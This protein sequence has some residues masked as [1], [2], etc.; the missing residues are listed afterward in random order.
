MS[1]KLTGYVWDGCAASGMKLSSVAIMARLADFSNDEG[2]CWPSIET[3]A[4]QIGA[5][6][7]T[8][9]TAIARLEAE[10]WLTRKARRQGNRNAS[11]VYQLN[12]AKL[13]AA[14]FSQL[15]DS[16][17]SKFDAS[18]S[19]KKAGFHPS[20]SGG[21]PSVKSK[22][23]PSDKKTSRPDASQ[24]DTQTAEQE[25]L[26]RH[27][28]AV[29][30][31]PKKRQWG[32]QDD[33]TCAQWLWKKIIALYEQAAECDGEV[34]RPKEPNWT[35]WANEIRLMCVQDGRTHK[36]ICEMYS[37]VSRDPFW[38]RNVLSPSKL[39][40]KWDELSLRL[41]PSVSTYT[42]KREDPYFKASYD[43][44]DYSQIPAGFRG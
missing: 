23:D 25:F 24:P 17:P 26:T 1:T 11:N 20:E 21:D 39:R 14:A 31:S 4:R 7:S 9:R 5:G 19:G 10:G 3:I 36:Q 22:H 29:V 37:R 15:S 35:A 8:V 16:D 27:P 40:E 44:V 33:L 28:D 34:V 42:E 32:T 2:V 12:V 6:M 41:S 43:N 18:K 30:F 38:C 13:Q